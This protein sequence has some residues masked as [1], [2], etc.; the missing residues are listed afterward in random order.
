MCNHEGSLV[1][2]MGQEEHKGGKSVAAR[3]RQTSTSK[4]LMR[5]VRQYLDS[6]S[7]TVEVTEDEASTMSSEDIIEFD[8][9]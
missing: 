2:T 4:A 6:I 8:D 3:Q 7:R 1:A 9:V 5:Q